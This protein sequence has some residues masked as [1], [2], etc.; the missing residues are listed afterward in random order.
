MASLVVLLLVSACGSPETVET[1]TAGLPPPDSAV[2]QVEQTI[3]YNAGVQREAFA[4]GLIEEG[5]QLSADDPEYG[6]I[7]EELIDQ[8]LLAIEARRRGLQN[9][10]EARRRLAAAEERIL[11]NILLETEIA[12]Q[13]T[14]EAALR[15]YSEQTGLA[16]PGEQIR[17][18][19]ILVDTREA[20][21]AIIG[22]A[23][24]G[25][26][27]AE[28]AV[29]YST[30]IATRVQGGDLGYFSRDGVLP[31][32]AA[33][34]F[35]SEQGEIAGPVETASG[36]HLL[37]IVDRRSPEGPAFEEMRGSIVRFL[38]FETIS[39]L[40]DHLRD[41]ASIDLIEPEASETTVPGTADIV[42]DTPGD[43]DEPDAPADNDN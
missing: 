21:D 16:R 24:D 2:A 1:G 11:G 22:L 25:R 32:I 39:N 34:A 31:E 43:D 40:V 38:T 5:G 35:S 13:V 10:P 12:E 36:W 6:R 8:R 27:F 29:Q 15:L 20:A 18:R 14:E 30:D 7:V 37:Y 9:T 28:L 23:N 33:L 41:S 17:A 19:H 42:L 4:Q 3:I 26:D